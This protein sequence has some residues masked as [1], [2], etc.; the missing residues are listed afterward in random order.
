[1]VMV[2][3]TMQRFLRSTNERLMRSRCA[4]L[5]RFW[6]WTRTNRTFLQNLWST[7]RELPSIRMLR[8]WTPTIRSSLKDFAFGSQSSQRS[9]RLVTRRE[10]F[11]FHVLF[12]RR[13]FLGKCC[14]SGDTTVIWS[15]RT[16]TCFPKTITSLEEKSR[17]TICCIRILRLQRLAKEKG[18]W[19]AE[20]CLFPCRFPLKEFG[21][22]K[23]CFVVSNKWITRCRLRV[24]RQCLMRFRWRTNLRWKKQRKCFV[25]K[26]T[27]G[28]IP[29]P[30]DIES[31]TVRFVDHAKKS[32]DF[33][34]FFALWCSL[35]DNSFESLR[36]IARGGQSKRAFVCSFVC[37]F[38]T[39]FLF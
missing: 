2:R 26:P 38:Y 23:L 17:R 19:F 27:I 21:F 39:F 7:W 14:T 1:M 24:S 8:L 37:V 22:W 36:L 4:L 33:A 30:F 18:W 12:S 11:L 29:C 15:W 10:K 6:C 28:K 34:S 3:W 35:M 20:F 25:W 5:F 16:I 31:R 13:M 9:K 32:I